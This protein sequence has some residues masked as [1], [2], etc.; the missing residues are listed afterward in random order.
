MLLLQHCQ[1]SRIGM[2]KS[3]NICKIVF[4][5]PTNHPFKELKSLETCGHESP[6]PGWD[7][8]SQGLAV[9]AFPNT[10][11]PWHYITTQSQLFKIQVKEESSTANIFDHQMLKLTSRK[12]DNC[13]F[14]KWEV[15]FHYY[16]KRYIYQAVVRSLFYFL[17]FLDSKQRREAKK[18]LNKGS[19]RLYVVSAKFFYVSFSLVWD[20]PNR[21]L[22][23]CSLIL[24]FHYFPSKEKV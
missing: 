11:Q 9:Q 15:I 13:I 21:Y 18:L 17:A 24:G 20:R 7:N 3:C 2:D 23:S 6:I 4:H 12:P 22:N 5:V 10:S 14:T 16:S 19:Q 8:R 1:V